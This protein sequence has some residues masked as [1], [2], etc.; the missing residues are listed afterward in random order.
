MNST[1]QE[2]VVVKRSGQRVSFN[3]AKI[4]IAIKKAFES[5]Y[6]TYD[7]KDVNSLYEEVLDEII[8]TYEGRKT[9][10]VEDIQDIIE[11][12]LDTN[13]YHVV[14]NS[15]SKYRLRRAAS[16]EAFAVKQQHKFVKAIEKIG[17]A[18]KSTNDKKP[19]ELK[20]DFARTIS[21]EFAA[22]YLIENKI[23]RALEEGNIYLNDLKDYTIGNISSVNIDTKNINAD[24][25]SSYIDEIIK[26]IT[27]VQRDIY[28][29]QVIS[30]FDTN[31]NDKVLNDIKYIFLDN[32]YYLLKVNGLDTFIEYETIKDK[33]FELSDVTLNPIKDILVNDQLKSI[34]NIAYDKTI[35]DI[36]KELR[37]NF[38]KLFNLVESIIVKDYKKIIITLD[39]KND[40]LNNIIV[41]E[42][43][44]SLNTSSKL[45]TN[46]F[47][48]NDELINDIE[49]SIKD[50]KNIN[51]IT[52]TNRDINYF[53]SGECIYNNINDD[54]NTSIGR[55]I[56]STS[57]INLARIALKNSTLKDFFD[58]LDYIMD[59][60][61][62][63][64]IDRYEIQA[65]KYKENY[66]IVFNPGLLFESEK[67]EDKQ[68]V[69]KIIR[70]GGLVMAFAGLV[71]A[72]LILNKKEI[73]KP[74]K[75]EFDLMIKI[76]K[77]MDKK[78]KDLTKNF[79]LNFILQESYDDDILTEFIK[80]DKTVY[81]LRRVINKEKYEPVYSF[82]SVE[83][84]KEYQK[85]TSCMYK[86]KRSKSA[87]IKEL[88]DINYIST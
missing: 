29:E 1:L 62:N 81:G 75:E 21:K 37:Q 11:K 68:K 64:L 79:K 16:R 27:L 2:L 35:N 14:Y 88:K 57:T 48:D 10:N 4:A 36:K 12:H 83:E 7:E 60:N 72:A 19:N 54:I 52:S 55:N 58:E 9:I 39:N 86:M 43:L 71:E 51:L 32:F 3:G 56:N 63:A 33:V 65:N 17:F 47:I 6:E 53:S 59:I 82:L 26:I 34:F 24:N 40:P 84:F 50:G 22:S 67:L 85:Y 8:T 41:K 78:V 5:V 44:N 38:N 30:S 74:E 45:L 69:R 76:L 15:F 49:T 70:N 66:N 13:K 20:N 25:T 87:N 23:L 31:M 18:A 77:V 28:K 61:K 46:I 42:Y 73:L 80:I